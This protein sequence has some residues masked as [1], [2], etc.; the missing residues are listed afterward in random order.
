MTEEAKNS[1]ITVVVMIA[2]LVFLIM[3]RRIPFNVGRADLHL[4]R[5]HL[6]LLLVVGAFF[7]WSI[8][9]CPT[10][11]SPFSRA[12]MVGKY[13]WSA[14][15]PM[16]YRMHV[17]EFYGPYSSY[18]Y[19]LTVRNGIVVDATCTSTIITSEECREAADDFAIP[20]LFDHAEAIYRRTQVPDMQPVKLD[21]DFDPTYGFPQSVVY[22]STNPQVNDFVGSMIVD[23]FEVIP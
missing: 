19:G 23:E 22:S 12:L 21:F 5:R 15:Q 9:S 8:T 14:H 4:G 2:L 17:S 10:L 18:S 20:K 16:N 11:V 3:L 7:A 1:V 6:F 13:R